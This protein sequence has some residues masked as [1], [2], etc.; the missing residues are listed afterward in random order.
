LDRPRIKSHLIALAGRASL[1]RAE[2]PKDGAL[3]AY[4]LNGALQLLFRDGTSEQLGT[5][6]S[7]HVTEELPIE[8]INPLACRSVT[9]CI[10]DRRTDS[11][12]F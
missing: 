3:F 5:G 10:G 11:A 1:E 9:L 4:V 6:D 2:I 8:W 12:V 7:I